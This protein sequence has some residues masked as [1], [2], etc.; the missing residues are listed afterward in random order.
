MLISVDTEIHL[1]WKAICWYFIMINVHNQIPQKYGQL[2]TAKLIFRNPFPFINIQ[3]YII[4]LHFTFFYSVNCPFSTN[5]LD[6]FNKWILILYCV[7]FQFLFKKKFLFDFI[8]CGNAYILCRY[9]LYEFS[10]FILHMNNWYIVKIKK[11]A[12]RIMSICMLLMPSAN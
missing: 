11:G 2:T 8:M 1:K 5:H 6:K 4:H 7:N 10:Q 9:I 12:T 3:V